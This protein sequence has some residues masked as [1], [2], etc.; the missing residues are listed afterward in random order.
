M[1]WTLTCGDCRSKVRVCNSVVAYRRSEAAQGA[2]CGRCT[3]T[4]GPAL[5][6]LLW[7]DGPKKASAKKET[8]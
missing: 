3:R 4:V 2:R 8:A 7:G 1:A 6:I 5:R